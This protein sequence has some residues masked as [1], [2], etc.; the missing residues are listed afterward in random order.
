MFNKSFVT[1]FLENQNIFVS[2]I[3]NTNKNDIKWELV[4]I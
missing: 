1:G 4:K 3:T 2:G